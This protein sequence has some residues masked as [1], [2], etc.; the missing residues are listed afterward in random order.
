V[1]HAKF[2]HGTIVNFEGQGRN[3]VVQVNFYDVGMKRLV[4][5]FANLS[6]V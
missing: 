1:S 5:S 2:G 3:A 6:A 4:L